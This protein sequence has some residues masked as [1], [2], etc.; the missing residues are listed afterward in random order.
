MLGYLKQNE[1]SA[2]ELQPRASIQQDWL[3]KL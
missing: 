2:G 1:E 3:P